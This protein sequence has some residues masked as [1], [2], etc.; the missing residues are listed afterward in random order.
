MN[1]LHTSIIDKGSKLL[2]V[3]FTEMRVSKMNLKSECNYF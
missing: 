1:K 2:A 3:D